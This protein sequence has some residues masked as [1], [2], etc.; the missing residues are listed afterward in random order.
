MLS[1]A[2]AQATLKLLFSTHG[3]CH[4]PL[5]FPLC[6]GE[7]HS[8][9]F[10]HL[11]I[12]RC[13]RELARS[14]FGVNTHAH[15][16]M[17]CGRH[18]TSW[19]TSAPPECSVYPFL[20]YSKIIVWNVCLDVLRHACWK[21]CYSFTESRIWRW[22]KRDWEK[23]MPRLKKKKRRVKRFFFTLKLHR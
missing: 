17:N 9:W 16:F 4:F 21:C 14:C 10:L 5:C 1:V 2:Q 12:P 19:Q 22:W 7:R 18:Q 23:W 11:R 15:I 3:S 13:F 8:L 6:F 20:H